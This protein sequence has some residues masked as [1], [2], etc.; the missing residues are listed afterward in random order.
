V[1]K[2]SS[3]EL[4]G[5]AFEFVRQSTGHSMPAP[6]TAV[7]KLKKEIARKAAAKKWKKY[8]SDHPSH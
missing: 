3:G 6:L 2:S 5:T 8:Y 1:I 7:V 4:N